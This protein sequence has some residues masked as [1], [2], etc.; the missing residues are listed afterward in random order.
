LVQPGDF[1]LDIGANVGQY[2][3]LFSERVGTGGRVFAFEPIVENYE[4]LERVARKTCLPNVELFRAA[5][6]PTDG[7]IDLVVPEASGFDGFYL[8]HVAGTNDLGARQ[9]VRMVS[10]D[11]L[12][13][14]GTLRRVDL[15]KCDVEGAELSV[16]RGARQLVAAQRPGWL[17]EIGLRE[18]AEVFGFFQDLGFRAFVYREKLVLTE[19]YRNKE[20]SNYLFFHP[21]SQWWGRIT[22]WLDRPRAGQPAPW[23]R[24]EDVSHAE[25]L[26]SPTS[27][28][29]PCSA[30]KD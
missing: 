12:F 17:I 30:R 25:P 6:G 4:V 14:E 16:L 3:Q 21:G 19:C 28:R 23:L 29:S 15:V 8:A 2:T 18:S 20:F 22:Q 27:S 24:G 13:R 11:S 10:L 1:V 26:V 5:V 9:N 7:R